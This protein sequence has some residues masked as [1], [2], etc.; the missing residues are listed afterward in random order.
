MGKS[1]EIRK[2]KLLLVEGNHER[3]VFEAWLGTLNK[4]DIQVM[5][6]AGKTAFSPQGPEDGSRHPGGY[7]IESTE[8]GQGERPAGSR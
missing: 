5:P 6:I 1:N 8:L 4:D 7:V 3:D 2:S